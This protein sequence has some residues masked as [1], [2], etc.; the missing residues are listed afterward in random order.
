MRN[1][2]LGLTYTN[3]NM[4]LYYPTRDYCDAFRQLG[5]QAEIIDL[6]QPENYMLLQKYLENDEISFCF[7]LQGI[8]S[9]LETLKKENLWSRYQTPFIGLHFDHPCHNFYNHFNSSRF[10]ANIY[11]F[12]SFYDVHKRYSKQEQVVGL[13]PFE[14]NAGPLNYPYSFKERPIKLLYL[15][16]G[17][18]LD[19][20][21]DM[22]NN[23][24]KP[25]RD[26]ILQQLEC[27]QKDQNL[28]LVNLIDEAFRASPYNPDIYIKEFWGV[29]ECLDNYIRRERAIAFV[30]WLKFQEGAV[31]IG[32]HWDFIDKSNAKAVFKASLPAVDAY[33]LYAEAQFSCNTNPYGLDIVHERIPSGLIHHACSISDANVWWTKH[34]GDISS[35]TLFKWNE[36]LADQLN[37]VISN[38]DAASDAVE[39]RSGYNRVIQTMKGCGNTNEI[40]NYANQVR[41]FASPTSPSS[42]NSR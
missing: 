3:A 25:L 40:I 30:E 31:I 17:G 35:L 11:H 16:T 23:L 36:P 27:V 39:S 18:A 28:D 34:F 15:K 37:P 33:Q 7:A 21:K 32:D 4:S 2:I 12:R 29:I 22:I 5:Y 38:I 20:Y 24:P 13:L 26:N 19:E 42:I 6:L 9:R 1:R 10:V 41:H 14:F 8:G